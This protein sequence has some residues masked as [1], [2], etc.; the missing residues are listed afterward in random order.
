[1]KFLKKFYTKN[2]FSYIVYF[3]CIFV[4]FNKFIIIYSCAF[5]L[6]LSRMI[7]FHFAII[8]YYT[9]FMHLFVYFLVRFLNF[10]IL[11]LEKSSS[12][13]TKIPSKLSSYNIK[14]IFNKFAIGLLLW[15]IYRTRLLNMVIK[16]NHSISNTIRVN[17]KI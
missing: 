11:D 15:R 10:A 13:H 14:L 1:M 16:W 5:I 6:I 8:I 7:Y 3:Y 4:C 9:I 2:I 17:N 12:P